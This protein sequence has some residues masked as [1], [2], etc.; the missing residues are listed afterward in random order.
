MWSRFALT[1]GRP[2]ARSPWR[3]RGAGLWAGRRRGSM[4]GLRGLRVARGNKKPNSLPVDSTLPG[5][6]PRAGK[7]AERILGSPR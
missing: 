3:D 5:T 2:V 6:I 4:R 7:A 1:P